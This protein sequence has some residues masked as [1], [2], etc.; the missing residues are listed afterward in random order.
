M[1]K[2]EIKITAKSNYEK[3]KRQGIGA[4][5]TMDTGGSVPVPVKTPEEVEKE[6]RIKDVCLNCKKKVCKGSQRCFE[7]ERNKN[8]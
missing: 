7:K 3:N 4:L 1:E 6:N 8:R 5:L 2:I